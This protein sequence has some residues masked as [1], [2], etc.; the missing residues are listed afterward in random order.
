MITRNGIFYDLTNS[1]YKHKIEDLTYVFSSKL[2]LEKFVKKLQENRDIINYSLSK[3]F[4]YSVDVSQLADL[5]LYKKIESRGFLIISDRGNSL[6]KDHIK[7]AGGKVTI[8]T[9]EE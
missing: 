4:G 6:C 2:H 8:K 5:V 3:R 9:L 1:H 7:Y